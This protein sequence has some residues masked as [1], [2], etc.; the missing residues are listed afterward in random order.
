MKNVKNWNEFTNEGKFFS[1]I[2]SS[3]S[4]KLKQGELDDVVQGILDD[5]QSNF[6]ISKLKKSVRNQERSLPGYDYI[7]SK[8]DKIKSTISSLCLNDKD[9]ILDDDVNPHYL[10]DIYDFLNDKFKNIEEEIYRSKVKSKRTN[11]R[12][13]YNDK[14]ISDDDE[15]L[16]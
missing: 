1:N 9:W 2:R 7:T 6:D 14:Y 8:G 16:N 10:S 13:K 15:S 11:I 3:I 4:K 5:I 12:D